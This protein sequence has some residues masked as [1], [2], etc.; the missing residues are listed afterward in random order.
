MT[1]TI[2]KD[3]LCNWCGLTCSF[4]E[5]W[6]KG[7]LIDTTVMG[8][9]PSTP[10]NGSG[11]L[12]DTTKYKFS[13]CEFCLNYLFDQFTVP[14]IVD[15]YV[16]GIIEPWVSAQDRVTRDDWRKTKEKFFLEFNRRN[17]ARAKKVV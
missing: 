7:G 1:M 9:Y 5:G 10:G 6:D 13:I 15:S 3:N 16:D 14:V 4:G 11:A 8:G 17:E 2:D 12:D